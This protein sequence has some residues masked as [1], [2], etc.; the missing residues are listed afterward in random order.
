MRGK[1]KQREN[2]MYRNHEQTS[3]IK[4]EYLL[5]GHKTSAFNWIFIQNQQIMASVLSV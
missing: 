4:R 3:H 1:E 2:K 5:D